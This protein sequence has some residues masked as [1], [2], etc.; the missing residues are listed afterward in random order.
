[1]N[2]PAT[3]VQSFSVLIKHIFQ[4]CPINFNHPLSASEFQLLETFLLNHLELSAFHIHDDHIC[5]SPNFKFFISY[6][7]YFITFRDNAVVE[8]TV[9][10][11]VLYC[12][13]CKHFH[14]VLPHLFIVPHCQYSIPFILSVLFDKFYSSLTVNDVSNKYGISISTIYRW[15]KKYMCYLRYYMQLRNSYRM[16][17]F[18]SMIYLYEDVM[19]DIYDLSSHALFQYDRKLFAPS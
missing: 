18:I 7:R 5:K 16:S 1:M 11:P 9:S 2:P 14:A 15:I 19:N 10:I 13:N 12:E 4:T 8:E 3:M 6:D 17:F